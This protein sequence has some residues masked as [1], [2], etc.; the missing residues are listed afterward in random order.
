MLYIFNILAESLPVSPEAGSNI[1]MPIIEAAIVSIIAGLF[2]WWRSRPKEH[3]DQ[4]K[5]FMDESSQF[6]E[7]VRKE[8]EQL[9]KELIETQIERANLQKKLVEY[10]RKLDEYTELIAK[11]KIELSSIHIQL[12][13]LQENRKYKTILDNLPQIVWTSDGQGNV[14]YYNARAYQ[15]ANRTYE[16]GVDIGYLKAFHPDDLIEFEKVWKNCVK[17]GEPY[18]FEYRLRRG[19]DNVYRWQLGMA[20]PRINGAG[21]VVEWFGTVTDI[22]DYKIGI[23]PHRCIEEEKK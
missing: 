9:K 1:W 13:E 3:N 23:I 20:M 12:V 7:E 10:E 8:R 16:F 14:N 5:I 19:Y 4:F 15:Y 22:H 2:S 11:Q 17:T 6:R 21:D 18:F